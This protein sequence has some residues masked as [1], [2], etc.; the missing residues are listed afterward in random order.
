VS[1][2]IHVTAGCGCFITSLGP[3]GV[4]VAMCKTHTARARAIFDRDPAA[5]DELLAQVYEDPPRH[6]AL[7]DPLDADEVPADVRALCDPPPEEDS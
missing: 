4:A 5:V 1:A 3:A 7:C 2:D 6:R